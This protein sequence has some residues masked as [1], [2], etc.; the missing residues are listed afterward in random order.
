VRDHVSSLA[1]R[2]KI[3]F[4]DDV[5]AIPKELQPLLKSK[6]THAKTEGRELYKN[7]DPNGELPTL[8]LGGT[9]IVCTTGFENKPKT[10]F[11][12]RFFFIHFEKKRGGQGQD[13]LEYI[14]KNHERARAGLIALFRKASKIPTPD[15]VLDEVRFP[16]WAKWAYR[17]AVVLG[18]KELFMRYVRQA[19]LEAMRVSRFGFFVDFFTSENVKEGHPYR[20]ADIY[21]QVYGPHPDA[22]GELARLH[23][24]LRGLAAKKDIEAIAQAAGYRVRFEKQTTDKGKGR[25]SLVML[26][27]REPQTTPAEVREA[28][29]R[30]KQKLRAEVGA[31]W[32]EPIPQNGHAPTPEVHTPPPAPEKALLELPRSLSEVKKAVQKA[33]PAPEPAPVAAQSAPAEVGEGGHE[34]ELLPQL[35]ADYLKASREL[36]EKIPD[37]GGAPKEPELFLVIVETARAVEKLGE[38]FALLREREGDNI[39][40]LTWGYR[41]LRACMFGHLG[42]LR[43]L[44]A[45]RGHSLE[46]LPHPKVGWAVARRVLQELEG[47]LRGEEVSLWP[48]PKVRK[49]PTDPEP[50]PPPIEPEPKWREAWE[51][52]VQIPPGHP[53]RLA[54]LK[55]L[56]PDPGRD[57][58]YHTMHLLIRALLNGEAIDPPF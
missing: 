41:V 23:G 6:I 46:L 33:P 40:T 27:E 10:D 30:R 29:E 19:N 53:T 9:V 26:F 35:V 15:F 47:V 17:Y 5:D 44:A 28:I 52:F 14:R 58:D 50:T 12:D 2:G 38:L 49:A 55:G 25:Q 42:T 43:G 13:L 20:L 32:A 37:V 1:G 21:T 34:V 16:D 57:W 31:L 7:P 51:L 18:V 48:L 3:T 56:D 39:K 24:A 4:F 22:E 11:L 36:Q 45:L 8:P 54:I